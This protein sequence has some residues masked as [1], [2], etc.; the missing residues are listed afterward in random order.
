MK[1]FNRNYLAIVPLLSLL[2]MSPS[3]MQTHY[4]ER[5]I[6]SVTEEVSKTPKFDSLASKVDPASIVKIADL[7]V[8][9]FK[10]K[11]EEVVAKLAQEKQDFKKEQ[12]DK[13]VVEEQRKKVESLIV[14]IL[15]VDSAKK[16]INEQLSAEDRT[17]AEASLLA[18]KEIVEGLITDLEANEVLVAKAEE[19]KKDEPK[20]D[21]PV[22]A[23]DEPKKEEPK[24]DEPV[25]AS[26]EPKKEED[27]KEEPKKEEEKKAEVCEAEEKN[28]VLTAQVTDLMKQNEQIMKTMLGMMQ[29]MISMHQQSQNQAP[30]P[31]YQNS[32]PMQNPYQYNQPTTAG[33]WVYYPQ[34]FQP[35]QQNI[36]APQM[37]SPMI[38]G[39]GFYPDQVHSQQQNGWSLQP[40]YG[41]DP[42]FQQ[43][44]MTYGTFGNDA[45]SYNMMNQVPTVSQ[46]PVMPQTQPQVSQMP[47]IPQPMPAMPQG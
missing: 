40:T 10:A 23:T 42:R 6:A 27:K 30:N 18:Q 41:F 38:Q 7:N 20:K 9:K 26:E 47:Q 21:E 46:G 2:S 8:E 25:V 1:H 17:E 28:K 32:L 31:Y 34:G 13:T 16:E 43:Q 33:N 24:K 15:L 35:Q 4:G 19:P 11:K 39:G 44:P 3:V 22:V 36:F 5:F 45:F 37:Q 29:M 12:S 14:D